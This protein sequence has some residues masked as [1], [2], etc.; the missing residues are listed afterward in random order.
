MRRRPALIGLLLVA[1]AA[2]GAGELNLAPSATNAVFLA[3]TAV[4][5]TVRPFDELPAWEERY[6]AYFETYA[7]PASTNL[8][9]P[10]AEV[11]CQYAR[12]LKRA[13]KFELA[14]RLIEER[15]ELRLRGYLSHMLDNSLADLYV[16]WAEAVQEPRRSQALKE[17]RR[18]LENMPW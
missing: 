13:G 10:Y 5:Q 3:E 11:L 7:T 6:R 8:F 1:S 2:A 9:I 17:A 14:V 15:K 12:A 16:S 4:L 18:I